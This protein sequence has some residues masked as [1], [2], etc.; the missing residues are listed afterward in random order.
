MSEEEYED[1]HVEESDESWFGRI[2]K[3]ISGIFIGIILFLAAFPLLFWNEG[4][5]VKRYKTLKEGGGAVISV[6]V[7]KPDPANNGK[8]VH[9]SGLAQTKEMLSDPLF[10]VSKNAIKL[11]R[12]VKMYQWDEDRETKKKK[13]LGGGE[14]TITIYKYRKIWSE[15][16]IDS[17]NFKKRSGHEN[18]QTMPVKSKTLAANKVNIGGFTLSRSLVD[19]ISGYE[20]VI[21]DSNFNPPSIDGKKATLVENEYYVGYDPDSPMVGDLKISFRYIPSKEVSIIAK[22]QGNTFSPY[23]TSAGGTIELL[24]MGI[25][26]PKVMFKK[27]E[28]RN[29]WLTWAIRVGGFFLMFLGIGMIL[30]PLSVILDVL[31]IL[32]SIAETGAGILAFLIAGI[33]SFI[34]I[35]IAWFVYRPLFG[36]ILLLAAALFFGGIFFVSKGKK[37]KETAQP[38]SPGAGAPPPPP[39]GR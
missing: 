2:G 10:G 26:G 9:I 8:L 28:T 22:Q 33:F 21:P 7:D 27:A 16:I 37:K 30:K 5:A 29:K 32:G 11:K 34:T 20:Q 13:K 35:A 24:E 25:I 38:P 12:I 1:I 3:S 6:S 14:K 23:Q 39:P 31:P 18:P 4:R 15:D 17:D 19:K 36:I